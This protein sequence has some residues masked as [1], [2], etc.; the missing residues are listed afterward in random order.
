MTKIQRRRRDKETSR[1]MKI[2]A[3]G[4]APPPA[5]RFFKEEERRRAVQLTFGCELLRRPA[6]E[7][8]W[9]NPGEK[10]S[11]TC[12]TTPRRWSRSDH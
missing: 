11:P 2:A 5:K 6:T 8:A 12:E 9:T 3:A 10:H 4:R 7:K 1:Q